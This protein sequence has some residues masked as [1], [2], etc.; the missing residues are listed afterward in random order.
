MSWVTWM[1]NPK[2]AVVS[3][4][5]RYRYLLTR[6]WDD[7]APVMV[8]VM[9]NPSTADD[10]DDDPTIRRCV[11]YAQREG[12]GG[13]VVVNLFAW[14]STDP[15]ELV[16]AADPVGPENDAYITEAC[17]LYRR[18]IVHVVLAWGTSEHRKIKSRENVVIELVRR[19][20][21]GDPMCLGRNRNGTPRH[22]LFLKL[23]TP[24]VKFR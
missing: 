16:K 9:L 10:V 21:F 1:G 11:G 8:F 13:L 18:T 24:L 3:E 12:C 14:R 22:P 20:M 17:R 6:R 23:N 15:W 7:R 5:G 4:C 2:T 19:E